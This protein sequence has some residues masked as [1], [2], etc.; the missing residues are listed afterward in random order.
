MGANMQRQALPLLIS[1]KPIVGTGMER[2]IA[3]DS[4]MLVLAKRSGV[5]K[6]LDSSKIVIRVNNNDSVYNKKNLDVYN[7]IKYIRSNQNTCINQKPCVSLGEKVLKG[8][9][10]ADG[11]ST[12]LGELALGKNIRVAFMSWNGYN[13]ED[14]ILISERIVQ[15]NKFSSIHIQELSCDIK[16]TK[17]G[18]E[19]IIPYIP[20]LP[21]YMFNKLDKSGIIKI[22]AE[23]F[24][25][26]ILV[27]KITPKNAKKLKSEEKLL[28]AIFG[29]KSPEIKDSSLRVPHG[30]SGKVIDIKIFKKEKKL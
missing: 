26:D 5:V 20:G 11:S 12:D 25:G 14:S 16:D 28:I 4:G 24:E 27:S 7:L 1:E 3:A 13:F 23:V 30:I 19:K 15:Q 29:D 18:R 8:D 6:Y 10:L 2:I 17:V 21:K 9:V 22:G